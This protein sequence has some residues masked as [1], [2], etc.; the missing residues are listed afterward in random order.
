MKVYVY[1]YEDGKKRSFEDLSGQELQ[2]IE[3]SLHNY[4]TLDA[5]TGEEYAV[6]E[7][8]TGEEKDLKKFEI[9][10]KKYGLNKWGEVE[11]EFR[12]ETIGG[13]KKTRRYRKKTRVNRKKTRG[14]R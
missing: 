2:S 4:G 1:L 14:N 9:T 8:F 3:D 13:R 11:V 10:P 6:I 7:K 5:D 12:K